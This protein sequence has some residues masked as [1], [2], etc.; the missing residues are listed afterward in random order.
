MLSGAIKVRGKPMFV[1]KWT[2]LTVDVIAGSVVR[3][4]MPQQLISFYEQNV[5]WLEDRYSKLQQNPASSSAPK[6]T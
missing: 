4:E 1:V 6:R 5:K 2:D 3:E